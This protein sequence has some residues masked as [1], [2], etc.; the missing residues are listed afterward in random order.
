MTSTI[1]ECHSNF[2][3]HVHCSVCH[4]SLV[5]STDDTATM[6][7]GEALMEDPFWIG[8]V[9]HSSPKCTPL[10]GPVDPDDVLSLAHAR[11][12]VLP[13]PLP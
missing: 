4:L 9:S 11:A 3:D 1:S 12:S 2:L 5:A 6:R 13:Y 7:S 10:Q 8:E